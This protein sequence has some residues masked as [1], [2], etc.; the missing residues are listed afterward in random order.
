MRANGRGYQYPLIHVNMTDLDVLERA[1]KYAG[2]GSIT[3]PYE[4][5]RAGTKPYWSWRVSG[6][7]ARALMADVVGRMCARRSAKIREILALP[8][9][10][11]H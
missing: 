6:A 1:Q 11:I 9:G 8:M 7:A 10:R 5:R 2:I 4:D 3:G